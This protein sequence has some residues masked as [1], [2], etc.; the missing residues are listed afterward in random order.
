M[1]CFFL[2]ARYHKIL[3]ASYEKTSYFSPT[4]EI[5]L[6]YKEGVS[7]DVI[8]ELYEKTPRYVGFSKSIYL[9]HIPF[10]KQNNNRRQKK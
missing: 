10:T 4:Y 1:I 3:K 2:N 8:D 9:G 5:S 7:E 6:K